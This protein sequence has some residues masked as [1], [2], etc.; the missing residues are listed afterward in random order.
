MVEIGN[1]F[2]L[3]DSYSTFAGYIPQGCAAW[4]DNDDDP[5]TDV[6]NVA[7]TW[8]HQFTKESGG[9][10]IL[11]S[12]YSGTTI[13]RTGYEG[14]DTTNICFV[15]R[16]EKLIKEGWFRENQIDTFMIFG[17]TND[18]WANSPL[19]ECIYSDWSEKDLYS[20]FPALCY[21]LNRVKKTLP[22]AKVY[23]ILNTELKSE[24][25]ENFKNICAEY[26][27]D[28]IELENISKQNGHPDKEG[29]AQIKEQVLNFITK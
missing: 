21:L 22:K 4:Y 26:G 1:L 24:I 3:G 14:S 27:V 16:L 12:S 8:W 29:M 7:D 2:I 20:V 6:H 10:L 25:N 18:N 11:N 13:C 17:G 5:K 23:F 28:L 9:N 19:G 15:G